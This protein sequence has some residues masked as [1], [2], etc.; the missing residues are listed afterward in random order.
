MAALGTEFDSNAYCGTAGTV[1]AVG[2]AEI[3]TC[4]FNNDGTKLL[5]IDGEQESTLNI[6][7]ETKE[8]TVKDVSGGWSA[9]SPGTKSWTLDLETVLL[10]D[11]E[12]GLAIRKALDAG[13]P[14]CVKQVYNDKDFTPIGGG[15]AIV[16]S[17]EQGAPGD[18][19]ATASVSLEGCGKWTW[20]D[21]DTAAKAKA[22]AK[23]SNRT[24]VGD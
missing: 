8:V 12:T 10:K 3:L 20:F 15:S 13:T 17:Y 1:D 24:A 11:S 6:E 4:I 18:D 22:T 16:T 7:A 2:G 21:I 14:L 9:K 19:V 23:P 5:A